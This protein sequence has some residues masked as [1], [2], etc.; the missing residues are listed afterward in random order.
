[1]RKILI[2]LIIILMVST[3]SRAEYYD[4]II[5]YCLDNGISNTVDGISFNLRN[6][7]SGQ[8]IEIWNL[9]IP[10]PTD[11][12]L[13]SEEASTNAVETMWQINKSYGLKVIE[14]TYVDFLT[15]QWTALLRSYTIIP[16]NY[17]ITVENTDEMTNIGMLLY[18]RSL[19]FNTYGQ[20]AGEFD[21]LKSA[22]IEMGGIMAKVKKHNL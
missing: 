1:M 16:T 8:Y 12:Q 11:D 3:I 19:N 2:S 7:G 22:I 5:Q 9:P 21:R 10:K 6:D 17:T 4:R 13:P 18:I 20:Y 14:N 15:N